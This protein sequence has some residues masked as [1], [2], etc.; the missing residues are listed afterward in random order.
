MTPL[1]CSSLTCLELLKVV[2]FHD[3]SLRY[4]AVRRQGEPLEGVEPR[5]LDYTSQ[6]AKVAKDKDKDK[7]KD[8][9]KEKDAKD[10]KT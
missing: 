7:D 5:V 10:L 8:R 2:R 1:G 6:Q 3:S 9:G 4:S